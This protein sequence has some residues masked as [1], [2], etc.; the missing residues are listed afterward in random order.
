MKLKT[1]SL[2]STAFFLVACSD[3]EA[4]QQN[5]QENIA[6]V[7]QEHSKVLSSLDQKLKISIPYGNFNDKTQDAA[8][9]KSFGIDD[10]EDGRFYYDTDSNTLIKI[11]NLG[12][13]DKSATQYF[14]DLSKLLEQASDLQN[15]HAQQIQDKRLSYHFSQESD[16]V[17]LHES[18]TS[19]FENQEL[20]NVCAQ[21]SDIEQADLNTLIE[22]IQFNP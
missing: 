5:V 11:L 18:C 8:F 1:F 20:Y 10:T 22:N 17:V 9:K 7:A 16:G 2:L 21:S 4:Q 15:F 6:D 19:I 14:T 13:T 3:Q 12:K